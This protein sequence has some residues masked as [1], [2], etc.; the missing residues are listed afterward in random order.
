M[1][2]SALITLCVLGYITVGLGIGSLA[3]FTH[4]KEE[5][6]T[7]MTRGEAKLLAAA[8]AFWPVT[9][10]VLLTLIVIASIGM[11]VEFLGTKY[12]DYLSGE[13]A[14]AAEERVNAERKAQGLPPRMRDYY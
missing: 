9:A 6:G 1:P 4:Q 7:R 12:V 10:P 13:S 5:N 3:A 2:E 11:S 14:E 8:S